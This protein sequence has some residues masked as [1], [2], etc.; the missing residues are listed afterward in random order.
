MGA[1]AAAGWAWSVV[2]ARYSV[3]CAWLAGHG[4]CTES[5]PKLETV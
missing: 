5:R 2:D 4:C 3:K 1:L